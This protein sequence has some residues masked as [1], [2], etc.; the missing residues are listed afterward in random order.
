MDVIFGYP[1]TINLTPGE[2]QITIRCSGYYTFANPKIRLK[3]EAGMV[4]EVKC[5]DIGEDKVLAY[6]NK[7]YFRSENI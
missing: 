3:V 7:Q 5:K 6:I 4:Y 1:R 2:Y